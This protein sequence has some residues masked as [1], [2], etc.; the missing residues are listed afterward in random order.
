MI[1]KPFPVFLFF[2]FFSIHISAQQEQWQLVWSDEFNIDGAPDE[3]VWN[4]ENGYSRNMEAQW[5][6]PDNA[7]CKDGYLVIEARKECNRPNPLFEEGSSDWRKKNRTIDYTSASL[8]TAGK[9]DF[10]YGRMEVRARV[11]VAKG[12][13]P[14]I[15]TLGDGILRTF[16]TPCKPLILLRL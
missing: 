12:A 11:P 6:Q 14:A 1:Q 15:W 13:W 16:K 8:T 4:F 7:Y 2:L 9:K 5:Y 3:S 10:L